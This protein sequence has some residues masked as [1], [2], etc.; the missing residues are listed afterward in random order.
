VGNTDEK[1]DAE[2][3]F[4]CVMKAFVPKAQVLLSEINEGLARTEAACRELELWVCDPQLSAKD[5]IE[6]VLEFV[7]AYGRV[8]RARKARGKQLQ[9]QSLHRKAVK[10]LLIRTKS[11]KQVPA[12]NASAAGSAKLASSSS[13]SPSSSASSSTE[14]AANVTS[15]AN[16][17]AAVP[18]LLAMMR[19]VRSRRKANGWDTL[20][21]AA[22]R[23]E[24]EKLTNSP[25]HDMLLRQKLERFFKMR[26]KA[27]AGPPNTQT[28]NNL[29]S[30]EAPVPQ[31]TPP[32]NIVP[33]V[34]V[35]PPKKGRKKR[36]KNSRKGKKR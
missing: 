12:E 8:H 36:G 30:M 25:V 22:K 1:V 23:R 21:D 17:K 32:Q 13:S 35:P 4:E 10:P 24:K 3:R 19:Q 29:P 7:H 27:P 16:P 9:K 26:A 6:I 34:E 15:A 11:G 14:K 20:P 28:Q 2:D 18:D 33:S 31:H 5:I